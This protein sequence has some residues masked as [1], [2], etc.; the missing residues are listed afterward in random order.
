MTQATGSQGQGFCKPCQTGLSPSESGGS[1]PKLSTAMCCIFPLPLTGV[2]KVDRLGLFLE[3]AFL[4]ITSAEIL[5]SFCLSFFLSFYL[6]FF[7][8]IFFIFRDRISR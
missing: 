2:E 1:T 6:S 7:F 3:D 8:F 5:S 4:I